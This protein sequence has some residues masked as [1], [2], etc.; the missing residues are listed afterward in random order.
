[1]REL[2]GQ[3]LLKDPATRPKSADLLCTP[4]MAEHVEA[5]LKVAFTPAAAD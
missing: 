4:C 2:I 1:L 5:W 3:M